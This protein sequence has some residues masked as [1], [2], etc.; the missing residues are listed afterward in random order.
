MKPMHSQGPLVTNFEGDPVEIGSASGRFVARTLGAE[1]AT[2][3][4]EDCE[5]ARR[6]QACWNA[7][8]G[9]DTD[10]LEA[11]GT[12]TFNRARDRAYAD[13][14][15]R[16]ALLLTLQDIAG[17]PAEFGSIE[18]D[19]T[20]LARIEEKA[21]NAVAQAT[22]AM[23]AA[24]CPDTDRSPV[25]LLQKAVMELYKELRLVEL[26]LMGWAEE[27]PDHLNKDMMARLRSVSAA[28]TKIWD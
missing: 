1:G 24:T 13:R 3:T 18:D 6:L 10:L 15:V 5:N 2:G 26:E 20:L 25:I 14:K 7:C 27:C 16:E 17:Y 4:E 19:G 11:M 22:Q 21:K 23:S 9:I 28:I 12:G 8:E